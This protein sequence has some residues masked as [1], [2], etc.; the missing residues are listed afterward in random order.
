MRLLLIV[1]LFISGCVATSIP[2]TVENNTLINPNVPKLLIE[3]S[4]EIPFNDK[5]K[6]SG[7]GFDSFGSLA[8]TGL[9]ADQYLFGEDPEDRGLLISIVQF[10]GSPQMGWQ[11][12]TP[13]YSVIPGIIITGTSELKGDSYVTG[14]FI[15]S[16]KN[17]KQAMIKV[18]GR[19]FGANDDNL[20]QIFYAEELNEPI[21]ISQTKG[22]SMSESQQKIVEEFNSR[23]DNSFTILPYNEEILSKIR[24]LE[25]ASGNIKQNVGKTK[26]AVSNLDKCRSGWFIAK[27][28]DTKIHFSCL[29]THEEFE[30]FCPQKSLKAN[31]VC[32]VKWYSDEKQ[33]GELIAEYKEG[34]QI[35]EAMT[36]ERVKNEYPYYS[37]TLIQNDWDMFDNEIKKLIYFE[38]AREKN[39]HKNGGERYQYPNKLV[40]GQTIL[41]TANYLN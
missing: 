28:V 6:G 22:N 8:S 35:Y 7:L 9:S 2:P 17:N 41:D 26:K 29:M 3:V 33:T 13:D 18:Y 31:G 32:Q 37:E 14:I 12:Y 5:G 15:G 11:M 40:K 34:F 19:V 10:K 23:A 1:T 36:F 25:K 21:E 24:Q 27:N 20:M 4:D 38:A 39:N 16:N 30:V